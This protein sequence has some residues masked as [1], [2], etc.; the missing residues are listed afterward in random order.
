MREHIKSFAHALCGGVFSYLR[1]G[2]T[3][4]QLGLGCAILY[5]KQS[6][7]SSRHL[8]GTRCSASCKMSRD[9][10]MPIPTFRQIKMKRGRRSTGSEHRGVFL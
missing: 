8:L 9:K 1:T 7:G 3:P 6:S 4:G 10:K 2:R 5:T